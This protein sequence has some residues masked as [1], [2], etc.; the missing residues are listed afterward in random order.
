MLNI[1]K[2]K[3]TLL[4]P[5]T[6]VAGF[7]NGPIVYYLMAPF[8]W[9][10]KADPLAGT[11][12][13]TSFS[14][15]TLPLIYLIGKKLKNANL[16]LLAAFLFAVSPLMID[17]SR[18]AFN[19]YPAV[20][21]STLILS[22]FLDLF[23]HFSWKKIFLLGV[24]LGFII[25]MHYLTVSLLLLPVLFPLLFKPPWLSLRYYVFLDVGFLVGWSPFLLFELRHQFLNTNLF[26]KYLLSAKTTP[27]LWSYIL[28]IW[29]DLAGQLFLGN[30]EYLGF[31]IVF[32][33]IAGLIYG[34]WKKRFFANQN[35]TVLLF[36]F[37][38]VFLVGLL[39]AKP[40][41]THYIIV[42]H[43]PL[44]ILLAFVVNELLKEKTLALLLFCLM[45]FLLIF[46]QWH[47]TNPKH[48]LQDGLSI[49]DFKKTARI[50]H[51]DRKTTYNVAMHAQ[52]DNR[53]MPLRYTLA[54]LQEKPLGYEDYFNIANLYLLV[55][56]T[57]VLTK[58]TMWEYTSFGPSRPIKRWII[59]DQYL[60]YKLVRD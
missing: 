48:P 2:G 5:I 32:L 18:A 23:D 54:L 60:L 40:L 21:F 35:L 41:Q 26:I 11:V 59:N 38:L 13:Q 57:E 34:Y 36:L 52:G 22:L 4:G 58:L 45:L 6:S 1:L 8:Y 16:G 47:W 9:L 20:F 29:P 25:Q 43:T 12:F 44:I 30:Q 56:K 14:L 37:S 39:Y 28:Q 46:P 49:A 27:K 31:L 50:I 55:R 7:Y 17:Y 51:N 33:M 10:L 19:A 3:L 15:A 53:A 24:F 42:F